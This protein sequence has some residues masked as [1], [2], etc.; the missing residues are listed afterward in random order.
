[1]SIEGSILGDCHDCLSSDFLAAVSSSEP[2]VE[3]V[4]RALFG[5]G[6]GGEIAVGCVIGNLNR[7]GINDAAVGIQGQRISIRSPLGI[8]GRILGNRDLCHILVNGTGHVFRRRCDGI[9]ACE[10][11]ALAGEGVFGQLGGD[12]G[13][14]R[15]CLHLAN[16]VVGVEGDGNS[17]GPLTLSSGVDGFCTGIHLCH[18]IRIGIESKGIGCYCVRVGIGTLVGLAR[19]HSLQLTVCIEVLGREIIDRGTGD[20]PILWDQV[21][22]LNF[23]C[24]T[25]LSCKSSY[26]AAFV[27]HDRATAGSLRNAAEVGT[28]LDIQ[29][30]CAFQ[31]QVCHHAAAGGSCQGAV[32]G[33]VR[34]GRV[35]LIARGTDVVA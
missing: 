19:L 12:A 30:T 3:A 10:C 22:I 28:R 13:K 14:S 16:A 29:S 7:S 24:Q 34:A 9:P 23:T 4:D 32:G 17:G 18:I 2:A 25:Q 1:M 31:D 5:A 15:L 8:E 6:G 11:I 35:S 20:F 27:H 26:V 33:I 21:S